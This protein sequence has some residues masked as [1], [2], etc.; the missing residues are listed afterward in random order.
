MGELEKLEKH[1]HPTPHWGVHPIGG[2]GG[3]KKQYIT[4]CNIKYIQPAYV[5]KI[6]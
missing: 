3:G 5:E 4:I 1:P 6:D 2:R